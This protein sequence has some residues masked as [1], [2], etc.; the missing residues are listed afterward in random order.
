MTRTLVFLLALTALTLV[1]FA[2]WPGID[3]AVSHYFYD[4]GGFIGRDGLE[5]FGRDFFRMAP[6]IVLAA[7]A[8]LYAL[9]RFGV[10]VPYAPSGRGL[11]FL[12]VT[13]ALGPGLIVNLGL[14]DHTHRPRPVHVVEFGGDE[15]FRPWYRFDGACRKNC[16]FVSGEAASGF[17]MVAPAVL[18]PPPLRG[19]AI[20]V[21]IAF[22]V[23]ASLLRIAFG[24]HF[25]SDALLGGLISLLVIVI[26][27]RV[28]RP[29]GEP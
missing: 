11:L 4:R 5:R 21:A 18:A 7:F 20:G 24:G 13:M 10:A 6:F 16:S 22:G 27:Y 9:R 3:L 17:W 8:A 26:A 25:L 12:A 2:L 28:I 19:P 1:V 14:K 29:R 23:G 15:E